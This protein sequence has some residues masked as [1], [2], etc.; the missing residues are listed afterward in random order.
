MKTRHARL[1]SGRVLPAIVF[2]ISQVVILGVAG[3]TIGIRL[4][5][6]PDKVAI[7]ALRPTPI[8]I[9]PL[10]DYEVVV[11]DEQLS[12][13]LTKLR[14]RM[15]GEK[16]KINHI[17][18]ALRF[19]GQEAKF[20]DAQ[21]VSGAEMRNLLTDNNRFVQLYGEAGKKKPLLINMPSGGVR[22]RV[23]EGDMSSSHHDHTVASLAEVGTPLDFPIVSPKGPGTYRE[24]VEEVIR[25]FSIN[26]VEYEWSA[27]TF[28]MFMPPSTTWT[29]KEGQQIS[30]DTIAQRIMRQEQPQG[31]CFGNHRLYTLVVLLRV[32]EQ[33]P[34]LS[35]AVKQEVVDYLR[36]ITQKLVAHQHA[37]G[38]WNSTWPTAKPTSVVPTAVDGDSLS[39]RIIATGHAL[40][41]WAMVPRELADELH[42]PRPVLAAAGQW[43][44]KTMDGIQDKD[45]PGYFTFSSHAGRALALWRNKFPHQVTL[46]EVVAAAPAVDAKV[47]EKV[48][49]ESAPKSEE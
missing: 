44:V 11:T 27:M 20:Q 6:E 30:F 48:V 35:P 17:D 40:E 4:R 33:E 18:H 32:N 43:I 45:V 46:N 3:A 26:Q 13:V 22:V 31:V 21:C 12:R 5:S 42:P 23:A 47:D 10:Y 41:W 38:F 24:M 29:T 25:E 7:P 37:D 16:T 1:R 39:D 36:D 2:L 28:A 9:S 14:P 19:W 34:I 8:A 49:E 15:A